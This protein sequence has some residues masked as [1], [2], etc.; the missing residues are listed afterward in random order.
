MDG[1]LVDAQQARRVP[2]DRL[3]GY[4]ADPVLWKKVRTGLSAGR[5]QSVAV[6]LIVEREREITAFAAA[7]SFK[8]TALFDNDLP[9]ELTVAFDSLED[10]NWLSLH[11][12]NY[13]VKDIQTKPASRNPGAP[14]YHQHAA[15][16]RPAVGEI[17]G[18]RKP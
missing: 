4:E 8:V 9:A 10:Q 15:T 14:F 7:S 5:V 6:R 1:K 13:A 16:K 3:V 11:D 2:E 17:Y 12:V 18:V